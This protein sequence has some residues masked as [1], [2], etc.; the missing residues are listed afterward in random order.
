[1]RR[2]SSAL[3]HPSTPAVRFAWWLSFLLTLTLVALLGVVRSAQALP[4]PAASG[5]GIVAAATPLDEEDEGEAEAEVSEDEEFELEECEEDE[6]GECEEEDG[7]EAP[8]ECLLSSA[9][10][11]ISAASNRDMVRLQIRYTTSSPTAV[12]FDYGLHGSKGSLYLGGDRKRFARQGVLRLN[13]K[14]T[15]AQMTKVMAAKSFTVR[16]RV[17]DAPRYCQPLFDRQLDVRRATPGGLS[18]QQSE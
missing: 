16:L 13:R 15:E 17:L 3:P 6:A 2:R 9:Q 4:A 5:P 1:M 12:A 14:L 10:A 8:E 11:T 7:V 18:W